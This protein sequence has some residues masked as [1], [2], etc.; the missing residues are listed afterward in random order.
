MRLGYFVAEV[1]RILINLRQERAL[2]TP[3]HSQVFKLNEY[4]TKSL[5]HRVQNVDLGY[6]RVHFTEGTFVRIRAVPRRVIL[7]SSLMLAVP[8]ILSTYFFSPFFNDPKRTINNW[9]VLCFYFRQF[10]FF[11]LQFNILRESFKYLNG[12]ISVGWDSVPYL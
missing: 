9:Y 5:K 6:Q 10:G 4:C 2:Y 8:G 3:L 12:C 11:N 7:W 1:S